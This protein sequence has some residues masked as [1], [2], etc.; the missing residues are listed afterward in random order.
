VSSPTHIT[1]A[2]PARAPVVRAIDDEPAIAFRRLRHA[3]ETPVAIDYLVARGAL[4]KQAVRW[5]PSVGPCD[6]PRI[7][8]PSLDRTPHTL[9]IN[10][11]I[12][13]SLTLPNLA[14]RTRFELCPECREEMV[15]SCSLTNLT[16]IGC[17][18]G[19]LCTNR[20]QT[21]QTPLS[22]RAQS[23]LSGIAILR[24]IVF[25]LWL[26]FLTILTRLRSPGKVAPHQFPE[27]SLAST[28]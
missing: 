2:P 16:G 5:L 22:L 15:I 4:F 13:H 18:G 14:R 9:D 24:C 28:F 26:R 8:A 11:I 21:K 10:T 23:G 25:I 20:E 17:R 3:F 6:R 7:N 27:L 1:Q 12:T 19:R